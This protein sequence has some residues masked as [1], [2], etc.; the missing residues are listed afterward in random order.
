VSDYYLVTY[1]WHSHSWRPETGWR[2]ENEPIEGCPGV[3]WAEYQKKTREIEEKQAVRYAKTQAL[4]DKPYTGD[5]R[6]ICATPISEEGYNLLVHGHDE[7]D[8]DG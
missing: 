7:V 6:F 5:Y 2:R 3:W 8:E 4:A 1:E